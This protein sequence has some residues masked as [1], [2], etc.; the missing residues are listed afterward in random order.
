MNEL[1]IEEEN[2][3]PQ[4]VESLLNLDNPATENSDDCADPLSALPAVNSCLSKEALREHDTKLVRF[5][6]QI[7]DMFEEEYFVPV[8]P[9]Y[10]ASGSDG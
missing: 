4:F 3:F 1:V 7:I 5:D 10:E 8:M 9:N 6:C 2:I